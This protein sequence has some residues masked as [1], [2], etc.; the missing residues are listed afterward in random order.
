MLARAR[1]RDGN[2]RVA[3][4]R[5]AAR[6]RASRS[7]GEN[8]ERRRLG[9]E[10]SLGHRGGPRAARLDAHLRQMQTGRS[11]VAAATRQCRYSSR[12][13]QVYPS[14]RRRDRTAFPELQME[15]FD[16]YGSRRRRYGCRRVEE[17]RD[18]RV[19]G[20]AGTADCCTARLL[21]RAFFGSDTLCRRRLNTGPPAPVEN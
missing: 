7:D 11:N 8:W 12:R 1:P 4:I 3:R 21:K 14:S 18:S 16:I 2:D 13:K 19:T 5:R 17:Y 6:R 15:T 9:R 20:D 10:A